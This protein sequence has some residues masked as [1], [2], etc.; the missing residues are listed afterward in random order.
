M[1]ILILLLMITLTACAAQS[2]QSSADAAMTRRAKIHTE[3]ASGYYAQGELGVALEEFS[4]AVQLDPNYAPA[5]T[6]LGLVHASLRQDDKAEANFKRSLQ[7]DPGSSE[8]HNNYGTFLCTRERFDESITE[9]LAAVSNPLYS[10]PESAYLNAGI[11]AKRKNDDK[12]AEEYLSKALQ[13]QPGLR[14]ASL[15]LADINHANADNVSARKNLQRA[16]SNGE[17]TAEMLWLAVRIERALGDKDAEAS[18]SLLLRKKYPDAE[19]T[20]AMLAE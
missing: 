20:R 17:P 4:E 6:G 13:I 10:T 1:K 7:L 18:Y 12:R 2:T 5:Y 11:C 16:M 15:I 19:Q 14:H 8:S 9:F 3:L